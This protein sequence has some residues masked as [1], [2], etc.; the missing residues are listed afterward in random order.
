VVGES[1]VTLLA[2]LQRTE[3]VLWKL[4][5]TLRLSA[6]FALEPNAGI[7]V[8]LRVQHQALLAWVL[9]HVVVRL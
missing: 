3:Q 2:Q 9:A 7:A 6:Q 4:D 1:I 5:L 8:L